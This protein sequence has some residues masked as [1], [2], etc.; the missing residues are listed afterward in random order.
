MGQ[1]PDGAAASQTYLGR[2]DQHRR[3]RGTRMYTQ[4]KYLAAERRSAELRGNAE[5]THVIAGG[6][7]PTRGSDRRRRTG[8]LTI[9]ASS[10]TAHLTR[11][12]A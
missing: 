11:A 5:R 2:I 12:R 7:P 9:L 4:L 8:H 3:L 1:F 10:L 6:E